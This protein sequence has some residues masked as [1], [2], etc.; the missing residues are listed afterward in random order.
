MHKIAPS[1]LSCDFARIKEEVEMINSSK[2]DWFH[3]DVM[4]GKFVPN[5]TFG[6]SVIEA[7]KR[8]AQKPLD[9]HLM[10]E[11]PEKYIN[12]FKNAGADIISVHVEACVHLHRVLQQIKQT[13]A[14]A[15]VAINPHTSVETLKNVINDIDVVC[16]MSVNPGFG[17][18]K[19]IP[20]TLNKIR[21][22][23]K[24]ILENNAN[25]QIEIDGG[26]TFEN[27]KLILEAGADI[28]VAGNTIF[29]NEKPIEAIA[30]LKQI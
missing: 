30:F 19:F 15:G 3:I 1:M 17:G 10:I 21:E 6:F 28:L 27:Y 20:N 29:K 23:K 13:G 12:D 5:I 8:F 16:M 18:Q 25:V 2:A 22:L 11:S 14:L 7:M 9:V 4:D 26:V 24:I